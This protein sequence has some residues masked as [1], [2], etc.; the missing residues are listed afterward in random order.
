ML[1]NFSNHPYEMWAQPQRE[2]AKCYGEVVDFPFPQVDSAWSVEEIRRRV[3]D[4]ADRIEALEPDAVLAAGEFTLLFM[5]VD[6][7]LGDG[8][9][10]ICTCSKRIAAAEMKPDGT[11]EKT[12]VF[13]FEKFRDYA[14]YRSDR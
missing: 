10:V 4:I 2:A 13:S 12:S 6:R 7:L 1:I 9:K 11:V 3:D 5:L 14:Y 8:V